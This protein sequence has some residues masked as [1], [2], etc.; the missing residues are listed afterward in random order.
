MTQIDRQQVK[1]SL[2][3]YIARFA[4]QNKAAASLKGVSAATVTQILKENWELISDEMWRNVASQIDYTEHKWKAVETRCS[5]M[6]NQILN[7]AQTHSNVYAAI[8]EA[9]SGKTFTARDYASKHN[10]TYHLMCNEY[11][12]KKLFMGEMLRLMGRDGGGATVGEMMAE[13]VSTLK[14]SERPLIILDEADKLS[15]QLL[16]FFITLYNH[17]EDSCGIVLC[18]TDHLRKRIERGR[19]L[20]K[21]GYNEIYS[22]MGREFIE[23]K[24]NTKRDVAAVC[25]A[26]GVDQQDDIAEISNRCDGDLRMVKKCVHAYL[27]QQ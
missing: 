14:K 7:D 1:S 22:R 8:A 4:S 24:P 20:N 12:N 27:N 26:N 9:G 17:L 3:A 18:A 13:I 25:T 6:F 21:R 15:D 5:K 23:I 2:T 11:W 16:F 10:R 19:R